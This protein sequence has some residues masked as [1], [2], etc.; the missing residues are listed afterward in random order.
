MVY[1]AKPPEVGDV[2]TAETKLRLS[3]MAVSISARRQIFKANG[4]G[5]SFISEYA[6]AQ[7]NCEQLW[8]V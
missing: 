1:G 5:F 7:F 6:R 3:S 2:L 4:I 8:I